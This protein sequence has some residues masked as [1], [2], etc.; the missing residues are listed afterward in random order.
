MELAIEKNIEWNIEQIALF[1]R[2]AARKK[3]RKQRSGYYKAAF[4]FSASIVE[5]VVFTIIKK[6]CLSNK[7][8][9]HR[10]EY[11]YKCLHNLPKNLFGNAQG[12]IMICERV[13]LGFQWKGSMDFQSLN[14]IG[15]KYKLFN[16]R[17]Y[18][19]LDQIRKKRNRIHIQSL[20]RKDHRYTKQDIEYV[21]SVLPQLLQIESKQK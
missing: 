17:L 9:T 5:A 6:F 19:K 12:D 20:Q 21:T 10:Q 16:K 4:L 7:Q 13:I 15:K 2:E 14:E 11:N 3:L 1:V 8:V 18:N